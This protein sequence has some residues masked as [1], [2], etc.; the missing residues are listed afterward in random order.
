ML[1]Q[2]C[3]PTVNSGAP[4]T[5][6]DSWFR[7]LTCDV[8][9]AHLLPVRRVSSFATHADGENALWRR[10]TIPS[11]TLSSVMAKGP[12]LKSLKHSHST[13]SS[14]MT[15]VLTDMVSAKTLLIGTVMVLYK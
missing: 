6:E 10:V 15:M 5:Y 9:P 14:S 11:G 7:K 2:N 4:P 1:R 13:V 8:G 3:A 12:T